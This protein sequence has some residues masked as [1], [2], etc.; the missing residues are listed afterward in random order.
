MD[1]IDISQCQN[2]DRNLNQLDTTLGESAQ[3]SGGVRKLRKTSRRRKAMINQ[4]EMYVKSGII[5]QKHA[6]EQLIEFERNKLKKS[7]LNEA[8]RRAKL[9]KA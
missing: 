6:Y 3:F 4:L 2:T 5:S 9:Q 8:H 1:I 7:L